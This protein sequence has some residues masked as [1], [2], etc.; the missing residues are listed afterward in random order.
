[1]CVCVLRVTHH[2]DA[3]TI[4]YTLTSCRWVEQSI[5]PVPIFPSFV[6][7]PCKLIELHLQ[8][9]DGGPNLCVA[10]S[11]VS[12]LYVRAPPYTVRLTEGL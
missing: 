11:S 5:Y 12:C 7:D 4:I 3:Y 2:K 8:R 6:A 9:L 1:M 10:V